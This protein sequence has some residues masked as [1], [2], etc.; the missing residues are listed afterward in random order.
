[1]SFDHRLHIGRHPSSDVRAHGLERSAQHDAHVRDREHEVLGTAREDQ[2]VSLQRAASSEHVERR[3]AHH[4]MGEGGDHGLDAG[5]VAIGCHHAIR[6]SLGDKAGNA[7][8]IEGRH[9]PCAE[10]VRVQYGL[11]KIGHDQGGARQE[12]SQHQQQ[13]RHAMLHAAGPR[14]VPFDAAPVAGVALVWA[15]VELTG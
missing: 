6:D 5:E 7:R 13:C 8:P 4:G 11:G 10:G 1:M 12:Q 15:T 14:R 3:R 2:P 9:E